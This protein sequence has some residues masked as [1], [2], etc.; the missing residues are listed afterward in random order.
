MEWIRSWKLEAGSDRRKLL[1]SH[2]LAADPTFCPIGPRPDAASQPCRRGV[3]PKG[4]SNLT[5]NQNRNL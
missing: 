3:R 1:L 4:H 5:E 2:S